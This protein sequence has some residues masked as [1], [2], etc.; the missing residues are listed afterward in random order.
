[1]KQLQLKQDALLKFILAAGI[2]YLAVSLSAPMKNIN[3]VTS[4]GDTTTTPSWINN[5]PTLNK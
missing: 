4:T 1:M 3:F 5:L 2:V